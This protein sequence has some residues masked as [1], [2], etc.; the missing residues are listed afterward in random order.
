[1]LVY[2]IAQVSAVFNP[3]QWYGSNLNMALAQ[4]VLKASALARPVSPEIMQQEFLLVMDVVGC[5]VL[6]PQMPQ[7]A[8][9]AK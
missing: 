1:M 3:R 8:V 2:A 4:G 5:A 6:K 9:A 7:C